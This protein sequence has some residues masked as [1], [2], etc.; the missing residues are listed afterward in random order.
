MVRRVPARSLP[1]VAVFYGDGAA[2]PV[3]IWRAAEGLCAPVLVF[4]SNDTHAESLRSVIEAFEYRID[5]REQHTIE[6]LRRLG[7]CG[8]TTFAEQELERASR[9]AWQLGVTAH[10]SETL[11]ALT[12][13]Y[14]QRRRLNRIGPTLPVA[15]VGRSDDVWSSLQRV[16]VPCVVKPRRG[17]G[18]R[19]VF[20]LDDW[21]SAATQLDAIA[22]ACDDEPMMMERMLPD[23]AHPTAAWL[24]DF[25]SVETAVMAGKPFHLVVCDKLPLLRPFREQGTVVPSLLP[26]SSRRAVEETVT[27]AVEALGVQNGMIHTEV[28]LTL[29]RPTVIEVNGRLTGDAQL[30]D[31]VS[32]FGGVRRALCLA[33]QWP[34]ERTAVRW[35]GAGLWWIAHAPPH[36]V[37][38]RELPSAASFRQIP[39]VWRVSEPPREETLLDQSKGLADR[40]FDI[41]ATA[42]SHERLHEVL[43]ELADLLNA[44]GKFTYDKFDTNGGDGDYADE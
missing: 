15:H 26:D 7:V 25:V 35:H 44:G 20:R 43:C 22:E 6:E 36:A 32:D 10:S 16:G 34:L 28:K 41:L 39:E 24:G 27:A 9:A 3:E 31:Q 2:G 1:R 18:S 12:D 30:L 38:V 13:K 29:P 37:S 33:M 17:W 4:D 40:L 8:V 11:A 19:R 42:P 14:V 21:S 5:R 23:S